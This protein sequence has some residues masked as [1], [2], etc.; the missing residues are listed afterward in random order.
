[1]KRVPLRRLALDA[2]RGISAD[3]EMAEIG[4]LAERL[5]GARVV[6]VNATAYGGGV[7]ELL[8]S[9]VPLE[10]G[11]GLDSQWWTISAPA[12]FFDATKRLH[13]ALQGMPLD[14]STTQR[15]LL[16]SVAR[17]QSPKLPAADV[18]VAHDPQVVALR[19]FNA[20]G[21]P[22]W[23]WRCHIDLTTSH[24]SA[25][26]LLLP[27]VQ[28]HDA[29]VFTIEAFVPASVDRSRVRLIAPAIDPLSEKNV[30]LHDG[31]VAATLRRFDVDPR[32]P[33]LVQVAR[34]D[35]WK[36]P[37]GVIDAFRIVR[38][39]V[40]DA[41]LALVGG[42]ADDDP[43]G[44]AYLERARAHAAGEPRVRILT[45]VD[46]VDA[47]D[48]NAFQRAAS[49]GIL[50]SLREGFGLAVSESL[51]KGVP[52]VGGNAGGIALQITDGAD[53]F[54]VADVAEC[55]DRCVRLLSDEGLRRRL[56]DAGRETVRRR[57]LVTRMLRDHLRLYA[58]LVAPR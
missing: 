56:G 1:M 23:I 39:R 48:V 58:D 38:R 31:V 26:A 14:L 28:E 49:V 35:P 47:R 7:A 42:L 20:D 17:R 27:Y 8:Q 9:L 57:F 53:G 6:H 19:H 22:R 21:R 34:F 37:L 3:D 50:K 33:L 29:M 15:A 24:P 41:Q 18:V 46:G 32:S 54:L 2:Y 10:R 5:R 51:W 12:V 40:P 43:E 30:H 55:A 11:V 25:L 44:V 4:A 52:V 45:N 36:D 16:Q 13:N